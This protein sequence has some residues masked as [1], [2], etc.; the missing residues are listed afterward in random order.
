MFVD[1][2]W[3]IDIHW[4]LYIWSFSEYEALSAESKKLTSEFDA[5][6]AD[7][8][9]TKILKKWYRIILQM[10]KLKVVA[11]NVAICGDYVAYL[12]ALDSYKARWDRN[13]KW[14]F[15]YPDHLLITLTECIFIVFFMRRDTANDEEP[16]L[17]PKLDAACKDE[18]AFKTRQKARSTSVPN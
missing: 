9:K 11:N 6:E 8:K 5:K 13:D 2:T 4:T 10:V 17:I 3:P 7:K 15:S 18:A 16:A 14:L 1:V 12:N